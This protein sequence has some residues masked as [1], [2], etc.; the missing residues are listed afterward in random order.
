MIVRYVTHGE[1]ID[2]YEQLH[3][4]Y[5]DGQNIVVEWCD[6]RGAQEFRFDRSYGEVATYS[7]FQ[8]VRDMLSNLNEIIHDDGEP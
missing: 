7:S 8:Q 5:N 1:S 3:I 4:Y 2:D 6:N